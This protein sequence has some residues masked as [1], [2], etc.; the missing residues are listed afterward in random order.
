M[1][2]DLQPSKTR[3][4]FFNRE[5]KFSLWIV[6]I[7]MVV[8]LMVIFLS[9]LGQENQLSDLFCHHFPLRIK[10]FE[11]SRFSSIIELFTN[12]LKQIPK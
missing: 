2:A 1:N 7:S 4:S 8:L 11:L 9:G 5:P 6:L 12:V 3:S 10:E